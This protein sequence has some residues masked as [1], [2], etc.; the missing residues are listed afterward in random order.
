[1]AL[2]TEEKGFT[3][4][5]RATRSTTREA[6][7]DVKPA[8]NLAQ[9]AYSSPPRKR[10]RTET[11]TVKREVS[12]KPEPAV[13]TEDEDEPLVKVEPEERKPRVSAAKDK[14]GQPKAARER[15]HPEPPKWRIQY[16][17]IEKMRAGIEAPVDT[18]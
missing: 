12:V 16:A 6:S 1:V 17:L 10:T 13:K 9:Y 7:T 15:A 18:M 14:Q 5:R 8:L 3:T 2:V 4:L 11:V